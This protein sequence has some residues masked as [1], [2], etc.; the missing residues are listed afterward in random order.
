MLTVTLFKVTATSGVV[1]Y[2][3]NELNEFS[4]LGI[5]TVYSA[6]S[7]PKVTTSVL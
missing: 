7:A 3:K 6:D 4:E 2:S 1:T 5:F